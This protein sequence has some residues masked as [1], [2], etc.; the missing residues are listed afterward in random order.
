MTDK[1]T[2]PDPTASIG[3][4]IRAAMRGETPADAPQDGAEPVSGGDIPEAPAAAAEP[5]AG[6][7]RTDGRNERG[8]FAP[9]EPIVDRSTLS[10]KPKDAAAVA[11]PVTGQPSVPQAEAAAALAPPPGWS[12]AGK[13]AFQSLPDAVKADVVKRERDASEGFKRYEGM[14]STMRQFEQ[15]LQPRMARFEEHGITPVQ[16]VSRLFAAF[17]ALEH[18]TPRA[19]VTLAN[20]AGINLAELAGLQ[21]SGQQPQNGAQP[22]GQPEFRDPRLDSVVKYIN[23]MRQ[24]D[25]IY[26]RE[27]AD[28]AIAAF[29]ADAKNVF[30]ENVRPQMVRLLSTPGGPQSLKDAYDMACAMNPEVSEAL[31]SQRVADKL[32]EQSQAQQ[33]RVSQARRAGGSLNGAPS[34]GSMGTAAPKDNLR[35]ELRAAIQSNR[36]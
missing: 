24:Q 32:K 1:N 5:T 6:Q 17:D 25:L 20:E 27:T 12:V 34:P 7:Q 18:D 26:E 15:V 9:R 33:A 35:E 23:D 30:F 4:D 13:A 19:L 29:A 16:G 21:Q 8:Q 11:A 3:E 2:T 22:Q 36:A 28:T 10:L 14:A 31:L